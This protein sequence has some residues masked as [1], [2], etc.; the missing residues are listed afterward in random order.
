MRGLAD[1]RNRGTYEKIPIVVAGAGNR[2]CAV[3]QSLLKASRNEVE[4]VAV[5]DPDP[6]VARRSLE[7]FFHAPSA[8]ICTSWDEA[9]KFETPWAFVISPN[10]CH[11][12][13]ILAA[14]AAGKH[15]FAE[16][17]LATTIADCQRNF[18]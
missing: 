3:I 4:V 7:E 12:E 16:K 1:I 13:Q 18:L 10:V 17:P 8:E 14:F 9:L 6:V 5:Y 2:A 15:V 11:K